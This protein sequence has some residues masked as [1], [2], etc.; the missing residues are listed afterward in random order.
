MATR[1]EQLERAP[2]PVAAPAAV[3]IAQLHHNPSVASSWANEVENEV[4][5]YVADTETDGFNVHNDRNNRRFRHNRQGMG[6]NQ[7]E[8]SDHNDAFG[9]LK[10]TMLS[11]AGKYDPD[12]YLTWE[13][14]VKQKFAC[15]EFPE[16]KKVRAAT[17]EFSDFASIWWSEYG[18]THQDIPR[19]WNALK[20][21]M[22]HMFVPSYY[23]R[24]LLNKL[25]RLRQGSSSVDDYYQELQTGLLRCGLK[26]TE[27]AKIARFLG[28]LNRE[29]QDILDFKEYDCITRLFHFACKA[30]REVQGRQSRSRGNIGGTFADRPMQQQHMAPSS[31]SNHVPPAV[32]S[33]PAH[34]PEANK[35]T[36]VQVPTK[37]VSSAVSTERSRDVQCHRCKGFGHLMH[38]CPSQRALLIKDN[39]EYTSASDI[40][41]EHVLVATNNAGDETKEEQLGH[42]YQNLV[43]QRVLSAQMEL[44]E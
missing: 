20:T 23:S 34:V 14:T 35:S 12:A 42:K 15:H 5:P 32:L 38:D 30:E 9:K 29:I 17:S 41:E 33:I 24:D 39:S 36:K 37:R 4:N 10:F 27:N 28:G 21:A 22:R 7:R 43:V 8:V 6:R 13:L 16:D 44:A 40:E 1:V 31:T 26:E 3:G 18:R 2:P 11:F 25:Q 19:T